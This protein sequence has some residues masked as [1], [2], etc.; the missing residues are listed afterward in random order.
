MN[1]APAQNMMYKHIH[2]PAHKNTFCFLQMD[3]RVPSPSQNSASQMDAISSPTPQHLSEECLQSS[4]TSNL[5]KVGQ[6]TAGIM[7]HYG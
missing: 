4:Q 1:A 2:T 5:V 3:E 7:C 6:V